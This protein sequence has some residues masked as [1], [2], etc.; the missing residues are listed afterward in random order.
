MS[1]PDDLDRLP[2]V[3]GREREALEAIFSRAL[4]PVEPPPGFVEAVL[5]RAGVQAEA[6]AAPVGE[7]RGTGEGVRRLGIGGGVARRTLG[8]L[9]AWRAVHAQAWGAGALAAAALALALFAGQQAHQRR[10][11]D[12]DLAQKRAIANQQFEA[13]VRILDQ[14]VGSIQERTREQLRR[15]G[16]SGIE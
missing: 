7:G 5:R 11:Q 9:L 16:V 1:G 13:S 10:E 15:A 8:K 12:R 6:G 14:T 3:E 2:N 4:R